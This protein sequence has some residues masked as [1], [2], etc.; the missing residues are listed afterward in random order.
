MHDCTK[1]G[2]I[3]LGIGLKEMMDI[4]SFI[5]HSGLIDKAVS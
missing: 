3:T 2:P 4:F 1:T 5:P